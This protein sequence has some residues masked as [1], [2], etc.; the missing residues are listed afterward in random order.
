MPAIT[1]RPTGVPCVDTVYHVP[2]R[3]D[4]YT[5]ADGKVTYV[6]T[7]WGVNG[8]RNPDL[9]HPAADATYVVHQPVDAGGVLHTNVDVAHVFQTDAHARTILAYAEDY[10]PVVG[11]DRSASIQVRISKLG[12]GDFDG[13]HLISNQAG[14]GGEDIGTVAM[15][16]SLNEGG[17]RFYNIEQS[18]QDQWAKLQETNPGA[19]IR[20]KVE[21]HFPDLP[22]G[23]VSRVP[24]T[25]TVRS[26]INGGGWV[27]SVLKNIKQP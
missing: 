7:D 4:F 21:A 19:K 25:I 11:A 9:I 23:K 6:E 13:G 10:R 15:L 20:F 22:D 3:G 24:D 18:L 1:D 8:A 12:G 16:K 5:G 27:R 26:S 2:G 14:A 17:G